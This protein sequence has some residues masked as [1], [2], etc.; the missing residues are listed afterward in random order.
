MLG[1][2]GMAGRTPDAGEMAWLPAGFLCLFMNWKSGVVM[3]EVCI[4]VWQ[5]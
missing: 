5:V 4:D 3:T 2:E 1:A